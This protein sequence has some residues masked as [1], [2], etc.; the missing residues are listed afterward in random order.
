MATFYPA[1]PSKSKFDE[2]F[3][4]KSLSEEYLEFFAK[5]ESVIYI[6]FGTTFMPDREQMVNISEM[7]K[8]SDKTKYGFVLSLK[9]YADSYKEIEQA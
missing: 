2:S 5:Y 1:I 4:T 6:S 3:M 8:L 7:I 9:K